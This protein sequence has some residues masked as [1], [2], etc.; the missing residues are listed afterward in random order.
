VTIVTN[1]VLASAI[2]VVVAAVAL[3]LRRRR[4]VAAPTQKQWS[5][6]SQM[7]R[8]DLIDAATG[9]TREWNVV[10][11]T[12][13]SCHVCADVAAKA[14]AVRS[15]HVA[16]HE[17]EYGATTEIHRKYS[18]D[19]VPTLLICDEMGVVRRHFLGPVSATDLWAAVASV[20]DGVEPTPCR[21]HPTD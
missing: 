8:G 9:S 15:R 20:R 3:F 11:F 21:E 14:A 17:F 12:S 1:L 6:P 2:V 13:A 18:I 16:V 19:A 5:V 10:V 4:P 7:D